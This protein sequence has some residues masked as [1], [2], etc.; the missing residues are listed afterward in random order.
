MTKNQTACEKAF[1]EWQIEFKLDPHTPAY[2]VWS[3]AY[4][5]QE[6]RL[7]VAVKALERI[8]E[9]HCEDNAHVFETAIAAL[10]ELGVE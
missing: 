6:S 3:A 2:E 5:L 1:E 4:S 8:V 7:Q 10:K 9:I